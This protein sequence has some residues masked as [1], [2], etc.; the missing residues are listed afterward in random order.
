[1]T[2]VTYDNIARRYD[3]ELH[4]YPGIRATLHNVLSPAEYAAG[5]AQ[6]RRCAEHPGFRLYTDLAFSAT[7]GER[8]V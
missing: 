8:P 3:Y 1:M 2:N 4:T 7:C 6:I 5:L